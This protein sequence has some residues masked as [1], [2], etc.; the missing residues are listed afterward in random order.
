MNRSLQI[1]H[2]PEWMTEGRI[3]LIQKDPHTGTAPDK[4]RPMTC[5]LMMWKI[6]TAQIREE[7]YFSLTSHGLFPEEQKGCHKESRSTPLHWSAQPQ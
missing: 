6:L 1:T 2:V 7:I 3:T 4:Y 5:L